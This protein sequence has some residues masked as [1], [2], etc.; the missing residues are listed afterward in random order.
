MKTTIFSPFLFVVLFFSV[1]CKAQMS[2]EFEKLGVNNVNRWTNCITSPEILQF[3]DMALSGVSIEVTAKLTNTSDEVQYFEGRSGGEKVKLA[4]YFYE[5]GS[6]WKKIYLYNPK[7]FDFNV[8]P[9]IDSLI[10]GESVTMR[11]GAVFP[12]RLFQKES[13]L[14][15][16]SGIVPSMYLVLEMHGFELV[17]SALTKNVFLNGVNLESVKKRCH[18]CGEIYILTHNYES[19]GE[20]IAMKVP[21]R[22]DLEYLF[23]SQFYSEY[24]MEKA[25]L[26]NMDFTS[27]LLPITKHP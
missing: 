2:L 25:F 17:S 8:L 13:P 1:S 18:N 23:G 3:G 22:I 7:T 19:L 21:D 5:I 9:G 15:Y 4:A 14:Y 11:T 10:S 6:G 27:K 20:I 16:I 12:A 24:L 26:C